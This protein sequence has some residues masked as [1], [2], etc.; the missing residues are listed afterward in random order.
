M[1]ISQRLTSKA[2]KKQ[3]PIMSAFELLPMCNLACKMCY[4]R[5][6]KDYVEKH[7]GLLS[8]K[9]WLEIAEKAR[10]AGMLFPLIT[11]GE[12]F[13]RKDI[14]EIIEG[15]Q[16]LGLQVSINTNGTLID[17][18]MAKWL[19]KHCPTRL[20][21]TLYG[22]S[23]E[24]YQKLCDNGGAYHKVMKAVQ[25]LKKYHIPI[26]FNLSVTPYNVHEM[27]D[28]IEYA[29]AMDCPIDVATYM[30]PP[31]RR[32][33]LSIGTNDRLSPKQAALAKVQ[34]DYYQNEPSWFIAQAKRYSQFID[35]T[36]EMIDQQK[37]QA[38]NEMG[39]RAGRCSFWIDW[40]GNMGN[41]GMYSF[42]KI[43]V[44]EHD[45]I[46]AWKMVVQQTQKITYSSVCTNCPNFHICHACIAMVYNECGNI[47]DRPVYLCEMNKEASKLYQEYINEFPKEVLLQQKDKMLNIK[48]SCEIEKD[49]ED[50]RKDEEY[51]LKKQ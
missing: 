41:C 23:E 21:I 19:S 49:Y 26:K 1:K 44:L 32:D 22:A 6:S 9:Q 28:I 14:K 35:L 43:N 15:M 38:P 27:K 50:T 42:V 2:V 13:L 37:K 39:C 48:H 5:K 16:N 3:I 33:H 45:F 46:N 51:Y 34:A 10:D 47:N 11:G 8:T 18:E 17:E 30:F 31:V 20:N 40:Q 4:V 36:D 24:S 25:L 29:H 12:P 7:G